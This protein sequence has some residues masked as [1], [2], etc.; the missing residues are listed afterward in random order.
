LGVIDG[1]RENPEKMA[2]HPRA[3]LGHYRSWKPIPRRKA[4]LLLQQ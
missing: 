4:L 1:E 2:N 3:S